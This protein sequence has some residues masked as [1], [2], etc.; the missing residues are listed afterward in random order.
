MS[1]KRKTLWCLFV[2]IVLPLFF[3]FNGHLLPD[4][5]E[6]GEGLVQHFPLR[7]L[8]AQVVKSGSWPL[9][10]PYRLSGFP[11]LADIEVGSLYPLNILF[12]F[13]SPVIAF[14]SFMY[15]RYLLAGIFTF[16]YLRSLKVKEV[17][18]LFSGIA[19]MFSGFLVTH[20]GHVSCQNAAIWLPLIFL[21]LEKIHQKPSFNY[22]ALGVLALGLQILAGFPQISVYTAIVILLYL[23]FFR[24]KSLLYSGAALKH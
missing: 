6:D 16:L 14:N 15:L 3:F 18:A 17:G 21:S 19:F 7:I 8:T 23:V 24:K 5:I 1:E 13:L 9:W 10:N 11:L 20:L 22:L 4:L 12:F 2:L